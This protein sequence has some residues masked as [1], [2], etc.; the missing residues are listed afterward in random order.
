MRRVLIGPVHVWSHM[1]V[2]T[3][4]HCKSVAQSALLSRFMQASGWTSLAC[5]AHL[6][7]GDVLGA[8][9]CSQVDH[10][11]SHDTAREEGGLQEILTGEPNDPDNGT[12]RSYSLGQAW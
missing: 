4:Q 2:I 5:S 9:V 6:K 7:V 1:G 3:G 10:Q 12:T 11:L 8:C